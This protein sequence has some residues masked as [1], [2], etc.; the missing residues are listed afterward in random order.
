VSVSSYGRVI[1]SGSLDPFDYGL[2]SLRE[3]S[4]DVMSM[5]MS[6]DIDDMFAFMENRLRQR[7]EGD[8]IL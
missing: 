8:A 4:G 1:N 3:S 7:V 5:A 2:P 6:S